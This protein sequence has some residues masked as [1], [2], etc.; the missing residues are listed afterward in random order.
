MHSTHL[1]YKSTFKHLSQAENRTG[2]GMHA[3]AKKLIGFSV[4]LVSL[5]RLIYGSQRSPNDGPPTIST[6]SLGQM[7]HETLT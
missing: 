7:L 3:N 4:A 2:S 6:P 1:L 5:A